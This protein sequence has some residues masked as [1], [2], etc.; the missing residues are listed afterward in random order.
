ME[1][2]PVGTVLEEAG[3]LPEFQQRESYRLCK[4]P[5]ELW[6]GRMLELYFRRNQG[7]RQGW[8]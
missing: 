2:M 4:Y 5:E 1:F 3:G 6:N 8:L 7:R